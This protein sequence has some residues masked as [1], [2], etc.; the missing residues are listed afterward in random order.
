MTA[1]RLLIHAVVLYASIMLVVW[2]EFSLLGAMLWVLLLLLWRWAISFSGVI[3]PE[4]VPELELDSISASHFVEKVRWCLDRLG[5]DYVE[6]PSGGA[7]GAFFLGR[8]VPR[9]KFRTGAVR[10]SIGNSPEI[11]R[12]LWGRYG[13]ADPAAAAFL[14]PTTE[15]LEL[16]RKIDRSGVDLQVWVYFHILDDKELTQHAWGVN[17]DRIPPWHR[18]ALQLLYPVLRTL[19]RKTFGISDGHHAKAVEHVDGLLSDVEARLGDGRTSLLGGAEIDYV[20]ITFAAIS[21][22]WLQ[23]DGY[24]AGMADG[25]RIERDRAPPPMLAEIER[26]E[27]R[28]PLSTA[29]I[30]RLY[31]EERVRA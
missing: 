29:Y 25:V 20:D 6:T 14:E 8:T 17:S 18:W 7:L 26:W 10:S 21:G 16:E 28:F 1:R 13:A 5:V 22:L 23:P 11:L 24:G 30:E 31:R 19:I 12:Y 15:R 27:Q 3:A 2:L 9:L 4:N